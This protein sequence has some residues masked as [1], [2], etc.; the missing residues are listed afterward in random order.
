LLRRR[1]ESR[2]DHGQERQSKADHVV[3]S[4]EEFTLY[5]RRDRRAQLSA[6]FGLPSYEHED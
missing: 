4:F 5:H 6:I 3:S 1:R 2:N